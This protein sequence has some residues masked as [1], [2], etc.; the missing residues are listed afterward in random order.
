LH[1]EAV[2]DAAHGFDRLHDPPHGGGDHRHRRF[3]QVHPERRRDCPPHHPRFG[4]RCFRFRRTPIP[5]AQTTAAVAVSSRG[6][7]S[8]HTPAV[9]R[10]I[11]IGTPSAVAISVT[12]PVLPPPHPPLLTGCRFGNLL[13]PAKADGGAN[14]TGHS[15]PAGRASGRPR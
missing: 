2:G 10:I 1:D 14:R 12:G 13:A 6:G 15:P 7:R 8:R 9:S 5:L 11:I 4:R 3:S